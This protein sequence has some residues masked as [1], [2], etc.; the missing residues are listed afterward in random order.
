[1]HEWMASTRETMESNKALGLKSLLTFNV[2]ETDYDNY[3]L[4]KNKILQLD[5][6]SDVLDE[7]VYYYFVGDT[8]KRD[9]IIGSV[10][11]ELDLP[12]PTLISYFHLVYKIS[13]VFEP[14]DTSSTTD[15]SSTTM[16]DRVG[17]N[18]ASSPRK[19]GGGYG[20]FR[21]KKGVND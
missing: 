15:I 12:S 9:D 2:S 14:D 18:D 17:S 21:K 7:K 6:Q 1:M 4:V 11:E 3:W 8:S 5:K 13:Y 10:S 20:M 19:K 16:P